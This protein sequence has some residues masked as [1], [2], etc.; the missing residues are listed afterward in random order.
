MIHLHIRD[1]SHAPT[2]DRG[3]LSA[4]VVDS[5]SREVLMGAFMDE[6]A[7]AATDPELPPEERVRQALKAA[8]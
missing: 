3:L 8:A 6:E 4:V 2:L 1:A 5:E 7:L